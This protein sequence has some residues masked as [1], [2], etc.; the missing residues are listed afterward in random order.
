[1]LEAWI[2]FYLEY[3]TAYWKEVRN[4]LI[5]GNTIKVKNIPASTYPSLVYFCHFTSV[6]LVSLSVSETQDIYNRK[7]KLMMIMRPLLTLQKSIR[8]EKLSPLIEGKAK[9]K[10]GH[11]LLNRPLYLFRL[12]KRWYVVFCVWHIFIIDIQCINAESQIIS[13]WVQVIFQRLVS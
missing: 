6:V 11:S 1:M 9:R 2:F 5:S 7:W 3:I 10:T 8:E 13:L 4:I 12:A